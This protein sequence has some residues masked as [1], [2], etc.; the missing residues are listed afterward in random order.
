MIRFSDVGL[1]THWMKS[2]VAYSE[3][4]LGFYR[5]GNRDDRLSD[6]GEVHAAAQNHGC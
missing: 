4:L 5:F 6:K 1:S 3:G 2:N